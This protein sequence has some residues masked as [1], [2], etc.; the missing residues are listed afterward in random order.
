MEICDAG[1]VETSAGEPCD[2]NWCGQQ[3]R[4]RDASNQL[5]L[6]DLRSSGH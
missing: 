5:S 4:A 1:T 6:R 2:Q 3:Q